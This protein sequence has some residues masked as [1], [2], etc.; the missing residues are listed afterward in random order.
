MELRK[1]W[2]VVYGAEAPQGEVENAKQIA[3]YLRGKLNI[4]RV[5]PDN[6][7]GLDFLAKFANVVVVG[8]PDA[9][10]WALEINSYINPKW[11]VTI[12]RERGAGEDYHDWVR[13]G[14]LRVNGILVDSTRYPF[15]GGYGMIGVGNRP[16]MRLRPL[17]AYSIGGVWYC[18]TCAV[19]RAFR[20]GAGPGVYKTGCTSE[21]PLTELCPVVS[22]SKVA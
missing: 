6:A 3:T 16:E 7:S 18:D 2:I 22:Y 5:L 1:F 8:G 21:I 19:G 20:E 15:V 14:A 10:R 17:K 4:V 11:D 13:S 12:L 9:N